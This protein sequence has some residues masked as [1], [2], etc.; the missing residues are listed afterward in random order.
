[1][2]ELTMKAWSLAFILFLAWSFEPGYTGQVCRSVLPY[3]GRRKL[4]I[5][6]LQQS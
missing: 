3:P 5:Y 6:I 2:V 4:Q 1:L